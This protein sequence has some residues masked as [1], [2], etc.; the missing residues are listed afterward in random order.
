MADES[1]VIRG[2]N[3]RETFPFTQIFRAFRVAIHPTKLIL[4]LVALLALYAGGRVLDLIWPVQSRAIPGAVSTDRIPPGFI[5]GDRAGTGLTVDHTGEVRMFEGYRPDRRSATAN[6]D[7]L[8]KKRRVEIEDEYVRLVKDDLKL[9]TDEAAARNEARRGGNLA[10]VKQAL[11]KTRDEQVATAEKARAS[12]LQAAKTPAER[13]AAEEAYQT[14]ARVAYVTASRRYESARAVKGE[15]IFDQFFNYEVAQVNGVVGAVLANDWLGGFADNQPTRVDAAARPRPGV[16]QAISN[17][18]VTGPWWLVRH[19]TWYFVLFALLFSIVWSIF[20]GAIARIAAVHV[21]RDEKIT[22]S[23]ALRFST[24]KF[25]SFVFAPIIP[26]LIVLV[27]GLVVMLGG[28]VGNIPVIGPILVGLLFFLALAA[29]F[30][31]TLVL[32]GTAGGFNLMYPTIAVEGS[33]SFD[34][35]SRSFSY[36]YARPWR[37]LFYTLLAVLYGA[38]CYVFVRLFLTIM[39]TL[40]HHFVGAG[41]FKEIAG[42]VPIDLWN[43]MWPAP[44]GQQLPYNLDTLALG[45]AQSLGAFLVAMWV[46]L[47]IGL[48]GAFA[49]SLYFSANTIIYFLMRREVDATELDDVYLEQSEEDFGDTPPT[50]AP[51]TAATTSADSTSVPA[52]AAGITTAATTAPAAGAPAA[53]GAQVFNAPS[54]NPPA[55]P[56]TM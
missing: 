32:L 29:G 20:G 24:A 16:F 51:T 22:L 31:M 49:I 17:F 25:P 33:D 9:T 1:H 15:G 7:E 56:P 44:N 36:V 4:A 46:Y 3:W 28:F 11:V 55:T 19:H 2:I 23:Q 52:T 38:L 35:I 8:R 54:G 47:T 41:M 37:M 53:G 45:P 42:N 10:A 18:F 50:S 12:A 5:P 34:A 6:F 27:V 39:L 30:V 40:T 26:L 48:L 43:T 14:A 21:A 13:A